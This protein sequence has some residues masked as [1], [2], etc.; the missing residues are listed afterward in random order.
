M[1]PMIISLG[2]PPPVTLIICPSHY[3]FRLISIS[4]L[5]LVSM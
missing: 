2:S 5:N 4:Y 1:L 3:S